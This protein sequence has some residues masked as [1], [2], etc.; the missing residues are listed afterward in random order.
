MPFN[1]YNVTI[2]ITAQNGQVGQIDSTTITLTALPPPP[3]KPPHFDEIVIKFKFILT[4]AR[5]LHMP[6]TGL[7]RF[8]YH[9]DYD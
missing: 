9:Y 8:N 5:L 1:T 6:A 4:R 3:P 7:R 2:M